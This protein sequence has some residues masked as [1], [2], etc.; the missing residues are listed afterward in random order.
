MLLLGIWLGIAIASVIIPAGVLS[1]LLT[2]TAAAMKVAGQSEQQNRV[3][4][5]LRSL[6]NSINPGNLL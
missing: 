6:D 1:T 3:E 4:R 2:Q 5:L